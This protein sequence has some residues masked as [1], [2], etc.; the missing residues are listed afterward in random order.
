MDIEEPTVDFFDESGEQTVKELAK[1]TIA[2][3]GGWRTIAFLYQERNS[4]GEWTDPKVSL[5]RYRTLNGAFVQKA[6]FKITGKD[7]AAQLVDLLKK[8]YEL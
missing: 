7:S 5:R 8:W 2:N 4:K 1:E 3:K 6:K